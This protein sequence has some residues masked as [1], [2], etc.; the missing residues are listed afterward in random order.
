MPK[1]PTSIT[2]T[3]APDEIIQWLKNNFRSDQIVLTTSFGMEGCA[4]IELIYLNGLNITV[5]NI[6]TGFLFPESQELRTQMVNRYPQ[7]N[8]ETWLPSQTPRQQ[9]KSHGHQLWKRNAN[10]CCHL[11]KVV[12]MQ[13]NLQRFQV[14]LTGIR[15][16]QSE[17]RSEL[18]PVSWDWRYNVLK[19]SP[20]ANW[21]RSDVW[22][23]IQSN[24]IPFNPLHEQGYPSIGCQP[25]TQRVSNCVPLTQYSREGRWSGTQKTEC[26]LHYSTDTKA[27]G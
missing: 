2:P 15:K 20:I 22:Q 19:V 18:E 4:L 11:R 26:G 16:S 10:L 1:K 5:A 12:P 27:T 24:Q 3:S 13:D 6:D 25:C 8:F 23:F 14:W 17:S 9:E 21:E 7:L